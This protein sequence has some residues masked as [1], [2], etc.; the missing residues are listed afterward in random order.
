MFAAIRKGGWADV[1]GTLCACPP[2]RPFACPPV[3]VCLL[4]PPAWP[5]YRTP[6]SGFC[7][8]KRLTVSLV[9]V[10][11][12]QRTALA[13]TCL[14]LASFSDA[15]IQVTGEGSVAS[16]SNSVGAGLG[17]GLP[18]AVF[19]RA[20]VESSWIEALE[21]SALN[22]GASLGYQVAI[23]SSGRSQLCPLTSFGIG[24]GPRNN[25]GSGVDR[26]SRTA[27]LGLA[28]GTIFAAGPE[29]KVIPSAGLFYGSRRDQAEDAAGTTLFK[30]SNGFAVAQLGVGIVLKSNLSIRPAM[31]I[32]LESEGSDPRF[33]LTL[34]YNFA[35]RSAGRR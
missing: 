27:S 13:Q 5:P 9:L 1:I 10:S 16:G 26:S 15:P 25:F 6:R 11:V 8:F 17:Y 34:G 14:G 12:I 24:W 18:A 20:T 7:M 30:V 32:T 28:I 29:V 19:G 31:E 3:L 22:V 4:L 2:V 23:G 21:G 35:I 33:G